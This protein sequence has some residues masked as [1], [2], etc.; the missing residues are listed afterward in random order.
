V[1]TS[2]LIAT[3]IVSAPVLAV[4]A[5]L[6]MQLVIPTNGNIVIVKPTPLELH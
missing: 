6:R 4:V 1:I 5:L 2:V 3:V